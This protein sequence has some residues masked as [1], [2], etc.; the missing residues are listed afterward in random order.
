MIR[1]FSRWPAAVA[2]ALAAAPIALAQTPMVPDMPPPPPPPS[3]VPDTSP[4]AHGAA[5]AGVAAIVNGKKI[6]RSKVAEA[7]L[8][9]V[10]PQIVSQMILVELIDQEAARQHVVVTPAQ[11]SAR[12]AQVRQQ[13]ATYPGGLDAYLAA[14]H[15][16]LGEFK[17]LQLTQ[18]KAEALV[19]KTL[20]PTPAP[21]EYHARHLLIAT[22]PVGGGAKPH[23]DAEALAIIAKAQAELK[24]GASFVDVA[25]KYTE[26]PSGKGN[27]GDLPGVVDASTSFDPTFLKAMLALKPGEV[28]SAPV[29]SQ[30]GYHLIKI[31]STSAAPTPADAKRFADAA[32]AARQKLVQQAFGP[33][34]QALR[35]RAKI[36]DYLGAAP[37]FA[38]TPAPSV[39]QGY[40]SVPM[41]RPTP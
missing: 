36:V 41:P 11:M 31:D 29:K 17:A 25:N 18:L 23:T 40:R 12:V 26:D 3:A 30:F 6:P 32:T 34:I 28:T 4:A 27:G 1:R 35:G 8:R 5:P 24:A 15:Q 20:K 19:V 2:L 9:A 14:H 39:G 37:T 13:A 7:A 16:T 21:L 33:Y 22:V 38:P 10:G